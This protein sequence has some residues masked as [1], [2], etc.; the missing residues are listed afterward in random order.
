MV[1]L[2]PE[3]A[4]AGQHLVGHGAQR[5]D[6][7]AMVVA[8]AADALGRQ[9]V[10]GAHHPLL[11]RGVLGRLLGADQAGDAEVDHLDHAAA[12]AGR[13]QHDVVG[14]DVEVDDPL[15]VRG[16]Q[17]LAGH[18]QGR[19]RAVD[20]QVL[21]H[22]QHG[23]QAGPVD[24]LHHVEDLPVG[25]LA[26]VGHVANVR[27]AD[28]RRRARLL[29]KTLNRLGIAGAGRQQG[30]QGHALLEVDVLGFV[31]GAH[32]ARADP[33]DDT[34][35]RAGYDLAR[36]QGQLRGA[37]GEAVPLSGGAMSRRGSVHVWSRLLRGPRPACYH[38]VT[39][40]PPMA[41]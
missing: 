30:L 2:V 40:A 27:A 21:V 36:R 19:D 34:V 11:G 7:A 26:E 33:G 32:G 10:G 22:L 28:L 38:A 14:L 6:V 31:D 16:A 39:R 29:A 41:F 4:D 1:V 3:W 20:G 37:G 18:A 17:R 23:A 35:A 5:I 9:V 13:G 8:L 24:E 15:L 12:P 25:E